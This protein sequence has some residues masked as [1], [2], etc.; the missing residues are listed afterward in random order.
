KEDRVGGLCASNPAV[1]MTPL[2]FQKM[3]EYLGFDVQPCFSELRTFKAYIYSKIVYFNPDHL[4]VTER[5]SRKGS[6]DS[7][8]YRTALDENVTFEFSSPLTPETI[9]SVPDT[10][11]IATG[12]YSS[13]YRKL[14]LRF[15]P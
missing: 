9:H 8:L 3:N 14:G 6:L 10:S 2:H 5:G 11:I 7:L 4:Y 1:H 13:L 12:S 15:T